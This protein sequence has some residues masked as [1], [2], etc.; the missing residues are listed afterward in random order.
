MSE[1]IFFP[2]DNSKLL[3]FTFKLIIKAS[4]N[5]SRRLP[6]GQSKHILCPLL[7]NGLNKSIFLRI[8]LGWANKGRHH[9]IFSH[10][11]SSITGVVIKDEVGAIGPP[12]KLRRVYKHIFAAIDGYFVD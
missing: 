4:H 2:E 5:T 10:S 11:F 3:L 12:A 9:Y 6:A 7:T 8:A 1:A